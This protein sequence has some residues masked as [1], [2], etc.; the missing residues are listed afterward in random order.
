[1]NDTPRETGRPRTSTG[2]YVATL[3]TA[4]L[5]RQVAAKRKLGYS[6]DTIAEQ[7]GISRTYVFKLWTELLR[8]VKLDGAAE[9]VM[10]EV[11]KLE[12][13]NERLDALEAQIRETLGRRHLL[14]TPKGTVEDEDGNLVEDDEYVLKLA[15]RVLKV[16]EQRGRNHDRMVKLRGLAQPV[17]QTMDMQVTYKIIGLGD[18]TE[19]AE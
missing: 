13:S 8:E 19:D 17:Q 16:E 12:A 4:E 10:A 14:V 15:D 9:A 18:D 1:V 6:Y 3:N 5:T 2:Q 11:A 7:L